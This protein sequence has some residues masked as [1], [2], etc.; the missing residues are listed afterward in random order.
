MLQE[1]GVLLISL[2]KSLDLWHII[3]DFI[4]GL[5]ALVGIIATFVKKVNDKLYLIYD[6]FYKKLPSFKAQSRK[7]NEIEALTW[8]LLDNS[9][10]AYFLTDKHGNVIQVNKT[11]THWLN[12]T[13]DELKNEAWLAYVSSD[14]RN[15]V[16][17]EIRKAVEDRRGINDLKFSLKRNGIIRY[18]C[19]M[20]L[21]LIEQNGELIGYLA[22]IK[23]M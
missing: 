15:F 7:L 16:R 10:A 3:L 5:S 13:E 2:I 20:I 23:K 11:L 1:Y 22:Q 17:D 21:S 18:D 12:R 6:Y 8:T 19:E 4:I 9:D 14:F